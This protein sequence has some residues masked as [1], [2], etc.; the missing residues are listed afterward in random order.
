VP[1]ADRSVRRSTAI[2]AVVGGIVDKLALY[3]GLV[4]LAMVLAMT[5]SWVGVVLTLAPLALL[6]SKE[7]YERYLKA[8]SER[9]TK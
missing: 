8:R 7:L 4:V 1:T 9:A 2:R 5:T 6:G 3:G